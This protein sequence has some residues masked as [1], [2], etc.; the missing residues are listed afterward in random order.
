VHTNTT[1]KN[2]LLLENIHPG[3]KDWFEQH[4]YRVASL[5]TSLSEDEL[6]DRITDISV[7][8]IRSNTHITARVL[9]H[10]PNL[11]AIGAFCIGTNQIDLAEATKRGIAV[12]N[13]PFSNTR[14]VAEL[15]IAEII[16]LNR[17]LTDKNTASH[18]GD[19]DKSAAGCHEVRGK[20]I[21][22]V[23]YGNVGSQISVL[24][25]SFGMQVRYFD[26]ADKLSLGNAT[27]AASLR[28]LLQEVDVVTVHVD[29]RPENKGLFGKVEFA[30]MKPGSLFLNLSR[31]SV[32]DIDALKDVLE[33]GHLAGA[34]IDVFPVEPKGKGEK[35]VSPLQ[36]L[37]NVI[38]TPHVGSGTE[39]AQ[40]D[41]G[42][43]VSA[44]LVH[45]CQEGTTTLSVNV[46]GL[47]AP[48]QP[49]LHRI[50]LIH[51]NIPGVLAKVNTML[52]EA[53]INVTGQHLNTKA[54]IG[55]A[56]VDTDAEVPKKVVESLRSLPEAIAFRALE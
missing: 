12:F 52:A 20:R 6:I 4:G 10:A 9:E 44:K 15:V 28:E 16:S 56:I 13:A 23:G 41:I 35:F 31:G 19:W 46:P 8:G 54:D 7:L 2:V 50:S 53:G 22:I 5:P 29:G 36:G 32:A 51:H 11:E 55:Y 38:L 26:I 27:R 47:K 21:G 3:A 18:R 34:A 45:Y 42:R 17:H 1:M 30:A 43:F 25:E 14:S 24:A 49:E 48:A 39:E 40:E 37:P 33:S